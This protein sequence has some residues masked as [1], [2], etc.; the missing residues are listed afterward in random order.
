MGTDPFR[1]V[2][3]KHYHYVE[4]TKTAND[5]STTYNSFTDW[6]LYLEVPPIISPPTPNTY[7]VQVPG[8]NGSLDLTETTMGMATYQDRKIE[9]DFVCRGKRKNWNKIY[10]EILNAVH[11]QRCRITCSDDPEYYYDGRVT[12]EEWGADGKMSFPSVTAIVRPFKIK[13]SES[14]YTVTLG[15][16][17]A[18]KVR[19]VGQYY[20]AF[21]KVILRFELNGPFRT[22]WNAFKS[23]TIL[24]RKN[25][26]GTTVTISDGTNYYISTE[27]MLAE[28]YELTVTKEE[29]E[30]A[31]LTWENIKSVIVTGDVENVQA[32]GTLAANAAVTVAGSTRPT[33]P[34][35]TATVPVKL[36]VNNRQYEIGTG[37]WQDENLVINSG[38]VTF[39]F[40]AVSAVT[41][42]E[43]V[44]I[45]YQEGWL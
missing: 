27:N 18:E 44:T 41:G 8:R 7:M 39:A 30:T 10:Q 22:D 42:D 31:G 33:V 24:Y 16:E 36:T 4:F 6:G 43:S 29:A 3:N 32:Y 1:Y 13:W 28:K 5:E 38:N 2:D 35:I 37:G 12:V 23:V 45:T 9:L 17:T 14:V 20:K 11:G 34:T 15:A 26:V 21:Q 40:E 19:I 25:A